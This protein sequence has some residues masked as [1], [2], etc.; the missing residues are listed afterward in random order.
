MDVRLCTLISLF[1]GMITV[2]IS[3]DISTNYYVVPTNGNITLCQHNP[4]TQNCMTFNQYTNDHERYFHSNSVFIF[5]PGVHQVNASLSLTNVQNVS[6]HGELL[7][8]STGRSVT[9]FLNPQVSLSWTDCDQVEIRLL[10]FVSVGNFDY[11]L[12][13]I[14]VCN[15]LLSD[16]S[17]M[18][19]NKSG[20][21]CSIIDCQS[22]TVSINNSTFAGIRGEFG[23]ILVLNSSQVIFNGTNTLSSNTAKLGGIIYATNSEIQILGNLINSNPLSNSESVEC[24]VNYRHLCQNTEK[25]KNKLLCMIENLTATLS[26][27]AKMNRI[28]DSTSIDKCK[29]ELSIINKAV[30]PGQKFTITIAA[31]GQGNTLVNGT[32]LSININSSAKYRLSPAVQSISDSQCYETFNYR[33]YVTDN[34]LNDDLVSYKLF[35]DGP[36][37]CQSLVN[38]IEIRFKILPCPFGFTL[39]SIKGECVCNEW[40]QTLTQDC[41]IDSQSILRSSNNFW[42][43][44]NQTNYGSEANFSLH[45]GSCP[46]DYCVDYPIDVSLGDPGIQCSEGREGCLCGTCKENFSL[47][48]GSL[49]CIPCSNAYLALLIPFAL[50]G[51]IV[52]I[53][54]FLLHLTVAAGTINGLIL[55]VNIVQ[56]NYRAFFPR[57]TV[58]LN[59]FFTVFIAW[60]NFDFGIETCFYDGLTIYTY[61]W[62]EFLFPLYLWVLIITIIVGSHYSQRISNSL[63]HNAV[64]VLDTI[65]LMS[66]SKIFRAIIIPLSS[67]SLINFPSNTTERVWLYDASKVYFKSDHIALGIFAILTLLFLF[68]PYTFLLLCGHWLQAKSHWRVLSWI[69]KLKPFMD[70]Y[71]APYRMNK[72]HWIGIYLLARCGLYVIFACTAVG[73]YDDN[74]LATFSIIAGLSIV[75]GR[76]YEKCYN[77]FLESSFILNLCVLSVATFYLSKNITD[78]RRDGIQVILSGVSVGIAFVYFIGIVVFHTYQRLESI[79]LFKSNHIF[80][81]FSDREKII[82]NDVNTETITNSSINLRELLLDNES[83]L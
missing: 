55:Y 52:V 25:L 38:G 63:G 7:S 79:G 37:I 6:F 11:S 58:K 24:D 5:Q 75:K 70:A 8:T 80:H 2:V 36:C 20:D 47:A 32:V 81:R 77:D 10:N 57:S 34:E 9:V 41:F 29:S 78:D 19:A 27:P 26:S 61:S 51:V 54:L 23:A 28:C 53:T 16:V 33:L 65:F 73:N 56:A 72:R 68:L 71:H 13:F 59:Y 17:I 18:I 74:L 22:S 14:N 31:L 64:A 3:D 45:N 83:S 69:N 62:L 44:V 67:T 82:A 39:D 35:L 12:I 1:I 76:V 15:L 46:L 50:S 4:V 49:N 40:L 66:Y 42:I 60:L 21:G 30:M 48:L 43:G